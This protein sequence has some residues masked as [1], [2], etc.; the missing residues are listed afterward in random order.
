MPGDT[1][2][3]AFTEGGLAGGGPNLP[4]ASRAGVVAHMKVAR[5]P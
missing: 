3:V 4:A 1:A 5:A 2:A